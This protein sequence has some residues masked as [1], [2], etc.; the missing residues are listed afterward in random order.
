M[1][2]YNL[3]LL[4]NATVALFAFGMYKLIPEYPA[5]FQ[6]Y[7]TEKVSNAM[8]LAMAKFCMTMEHYGLTGEID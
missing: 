2:G 8:V 5:G 6:I 4:F 3:L 1:I 7:N